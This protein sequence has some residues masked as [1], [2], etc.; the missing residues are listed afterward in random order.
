M[1][2]LEIPGG[3]KGI[4][5]GPF[6][7]LEKP[8]TSRAEQHQRDRHHTVDLFSRPRTKVPGTVSHVM[9]RR[10]YS[11]LSGRMAG[12][13]TIK[14]RTMWTLKVCA[15][16]GRKSGV[17]LSHSSLDGYKTIGLD[18]EISPF[19]NLS[20]LPVP[21]A[22][23]PRHRSQDRHIPSVHITSSQISNTISTMMSIQRNTLL[24]FLIAVLLATMASGL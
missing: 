5:W 2:R 22:R 12:S 8:N 21:Y 18:E 15:V 7:L 14:E 16:Y 17:F 10:H 13:S 9:T 11:R 19:S 6:Q 3:N 24:K 1:S 20:S 23:F 4:V